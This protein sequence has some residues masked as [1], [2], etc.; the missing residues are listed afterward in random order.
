MLILI[1]LIYL[2]LQIMSQQKRMSLNQ[3]LRIFYL[4]LTKIKAIQFNKNKLLRVKLKCVMNL[5]KAQKSLQR[6]KV[7]L[8]LTVRMKAKILLCQHPNLI[9]PRKHHLT[10]LLSVR[11]RLWQR[12]K[13]QTSKKKKKRNNV[14]KLR[15]K[16]IATLAFRKE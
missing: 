3:K 14:R 5:L 9:C 15:R 2:P 4:Q 10:N 11:K 7:K 1:R 12:L 16:K 6:F 8:I 13:K